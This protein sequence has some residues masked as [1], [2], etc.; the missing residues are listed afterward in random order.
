MK[1]FISQNT[2]VYL[3]NCMRD[4]VRDVKGERDVQDARRGNR[5]IVRRKRRLFCENRV[6][7]NDDHVQVDN[8]LRLRAVG[9]YGKV[10][11]GLVEDKD[12]R[13]KKRKKP[14]GFLLG[15]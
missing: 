5:E 4:C 2:I 9:G 14:V 6:R 15:G 10:E 11:R 3:S 1:Q 8:R 7:D 12:K 13:Q